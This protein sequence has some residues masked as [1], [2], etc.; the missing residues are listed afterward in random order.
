MWLILKT[1]LFVATVLMFIPMVAMAN[2]DLDVIVPGSAGAMKATGK[3]RST[4]SI[5]TNRPIRQV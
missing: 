4:T 3:I 1:T 2:Q 5:P